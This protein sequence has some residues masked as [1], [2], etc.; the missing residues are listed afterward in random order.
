LPV[1]K[2]L[3]NYLGIETGDFD[4]LYCNNT[5]RFLRLA[6]EKEQ[7]MGKSIKEIIEVRRYV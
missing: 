1:L 6:M 2:M 5:L 4:V 3:C 7:S